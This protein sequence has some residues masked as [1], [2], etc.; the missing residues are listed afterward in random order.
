MFQPRTVI[1]AVRILVAVFIWAVAACLVGLAADLSGDNKTSMATWLEAILIWGVQGGLLLMLLIVAVW[2]MGEKC[3]RWEWV[4]E[5]EADRVRFALFYQNVAYYAYHAGIAE[6]RL[7]VFTSTKPGVVFGF[8]RLSPQRSY[9]AFNHS[10]LRTLSP[11]ALQALVAYAT[12]RIKRNKLITANRVLEADIA[13]AQMMHDGNPL[14]DALT[15]LA[16]YFKSNPS[17]K[18]TTLVRNLL[19]SAACPPIDFRIRRLRSGAWQHP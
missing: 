18:R 10:I 4:L 2:R 13:T 14:A 8:G 15:E 9:I 5:N 3:S 11:T 16:R 12:V 17:S 19:T 6:P 7:V 1:L